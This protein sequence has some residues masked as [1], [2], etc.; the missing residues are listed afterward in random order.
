MKNPPPW[1]CYPF[2]LDRSR[3]RFLRALGATAAASVLVGSEDAQAEKAAQNESPDIPGAYPE[4]AV[5]LQF[6]ENPL[7]PSPKALAAISD[8]GL[9]GSNRYNDIAPLTSDLARQHRIQEN[10]VLVGCG[11]TEFLHIAPWT[12]LRQGG[13]LVLP[14]PSYGWSAGIAASMGASVVRVP[15]DGEGKID[16]ASM[17]KAT[18]NNTRLVYLANPNNP[19]GASLP[20]AEIRSL[21]EVLPEESVLMLDEAYSPFLP[22]GGDGIDLVREGAPV[23]VTRTFSK[24]YGLAGLRLGYAM[25]PKELIEKLQTFWL[26]DFGINAAV[27]AAAPAALTDTRHVEHYINIVDEG[28]EMHR[29][30]LKDLDIRTFPYRAPFFMVDLGREAKPIV[31]ALEAKKVYVRDGRAWK[32][33]TFLRV[34]IGLPSQNQAFLDALRQV[35]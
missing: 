15:T 21:V 5:L 7:G 3:R 4:D 9:A 33:P 30:G 17:R 2:G 19:T 11:S 10:Q 16:P 14:D 31:E 29:S 28:L 27:C 35:L 34:S 23:I 8:I 22:P 32:K 13:D 6:N 26:W 24:A 20:L 1:S 18:S 12:F 25:A